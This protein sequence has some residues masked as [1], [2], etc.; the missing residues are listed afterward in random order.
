MFLDFD[1]TVPDPGLNG[2]L[3]T[4]TFG[5]I[6][7]PLSTPVLELSFW[8]F[9]EDSIGLSNLPIKLWKINGKH[10]ALCN[11]PPN[12]LKGHSKY[13]ISG[14]FTAIR[15]KTA[16]N[17]HVRGR[18]VGNKSASQNSFKPLHRPSWNPFAFVNGS[19]LSK[20][21]ASSLAS[22]PGSRLLESEVAA[23]N[24]RVQTISWNILLP[25]ESNRGSFY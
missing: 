8:D 2:N 22:Y 7:P 6:I 14:M 17:C 5:F 1:V 21:Q 10:Y 13:T 18:Q 3:V 11:Y 19:L 25:K 20:S 12:I 15:N 24:R 23:N 16:R 4:G 9:T